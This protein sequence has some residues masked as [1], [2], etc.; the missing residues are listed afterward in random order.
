MLGWVD[1]PRTGGAWGGADSGWTRLVPV[2]RNR[3]YRQP[4]PHPSTVGRC[5]PPLS[6][7]IALCSF[8]AG[9]IADRVGSRNRGLATS[10]TRVWRTVNNAIA[11]NGWHRA[12]MMTADVAR[13]GMPGVKV[14][15]VF[16]TGP[17][18]STRIRVFLEPDLPLH[19]PAA[20]VVGQHKLL[21]TP[22]LLLSRR[23]RGEQQV[24]RR[25]PLEGE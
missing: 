13:L 3:V 2:G 8:Q 10:G 18:Y 1:I 23:L 7:Q 4:F 25:F 19:W 5:H 11:S 12:L 17:V 22:L 9:G 20:G 15:K 24:S 14:D 6:G 21:S 16:R